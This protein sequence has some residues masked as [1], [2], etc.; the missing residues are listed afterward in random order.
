[1]GNCKLHCSDHIVCPFH[2]GP[3]MRESFLQSFM[4]CLCTHTK[5]SKDIKS[6]SLQSFLHPQ[7]ILSSFFLLPNFWGSFKSH[8]TLGRTEYIIHSSIHPAPF[9][10]ILTRKRSS[11]WQN[12]D[13]VVVPFFLLCWVKETRFHLYE[14]EPGFRLQFHSWVWIYAYAGTANH[15]YSRPV[16]TDSAHCAPR[17]WR[18]WMENICMMI[19]CTYEWMNLSAKLADFGAKIPGRFSSLCCIT[20][21]HCCILKGN[22]HSV[23]WSISRGIT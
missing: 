21:L 10:P 17:I 23:S 4:W 5:M 11:G 14:K 2:C 9:C 8:F 16:I 22:A 18:L 13:V 20:L 1:M 3:S 6:Q 7:P 19:K 12:I 15:T